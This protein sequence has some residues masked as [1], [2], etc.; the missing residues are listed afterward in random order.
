MT[1]FA[2][3]CC[4]K[5]TLKANSDKNTIFKQKFSDVTIKD[6]KYLLQYINCNNILNDETDK[7]YENFSKNFSEIYDAAF[8]EMKMENKIKIF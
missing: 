7:S 6:F 5:A 4:M 3:F 2:I 1:F 8:P